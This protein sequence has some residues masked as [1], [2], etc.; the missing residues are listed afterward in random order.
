MGLKFVELY[1]ARGTKLSSFDEA[2][3]SNFENMLFEGLPPSQI[4]GKLLTLSLG[5]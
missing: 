3:V 1:V 2:M 4:K 5:V